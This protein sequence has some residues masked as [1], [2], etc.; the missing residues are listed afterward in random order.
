MGQADSVRIEPKK[1]R[2]W[3]AELRQKGY[4]IGNRPHSSNVV[5]LHA[6]DKAGIINKDTWNQA[7]C[8]S[9]PWDKQASM[10]KIESRYYCREIGKMMQN[11]SL[12]EDFLPLGIQIPGP[13]LKLFAT[14]VVIK[15]SLPQRVKNWVLGLFR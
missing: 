8:A 4:W 13:D 6:L 9:K 12:S 2:E 5:H 14:I 1:M 3:A 7:G 15:P 10:A 11:V